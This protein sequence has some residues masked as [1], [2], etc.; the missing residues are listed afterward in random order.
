MILDY[1]HKA[2]LEIIDLAV[3]PAYANTEKTNTTFTES[4]ESTENAYYSDFVVVG[5]QVWGLKKGSAGYYKS[6][7][8]QCW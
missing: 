1:N 8:D 3:S 2:T 5:G 4:I 7:W 6:H